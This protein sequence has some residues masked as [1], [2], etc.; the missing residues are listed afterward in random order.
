MKEFRYLNSDFLNF[1]VI[2]KSQESGGDVQE[3][4]RW[5]LK[6]MQMQKKKI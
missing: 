4:W 1:I 5:R 3:K 6:K 2:H